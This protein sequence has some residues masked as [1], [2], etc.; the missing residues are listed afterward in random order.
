MAINPPSTTLATIQQKVRRLTRSPST[1]QLSDDDLNQYINTFVV[2]DFPE[3]LRMFN[4]RTV[5][6]FWA[7]P[8]QDVYPTDILSFGSA[9]QAASQPLYDFQNKYLSI[10]DPV[11][12]AGYQSFYTQSREQMFG[13]YPQ[14]N[15]IQAIGPTGDGVTTRFTGFIP[16]ISTSINPNSAQGGAC[17]VKNNVLF[18]SVDVNFNGISMIDQPV[19]DSVTGNP[20]VWGNLYV[21]NQLPAVPVMTG[22]A[23]PYAPN[24]DGHINENNYVNYVTG[25]FVVTFPNAPMQ[26]VLINSQTIPQVVSLPQALM[27]YDDKFTLRPV[28]DQPYQINFEAYVRPTYLLTTSQSPALNEWWQYI[29]Y[30]A[31]KKIFEDR[32]D[33]DSVQLILPEFRKQETLCLRRTIVQYTNERV[34]TIYTEQTSFG[35]GSGAWGWGGGPF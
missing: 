2:Y 30:G 34:A 29:A 32:M 11:Y 21:P 27:F 22:G 28:P 6:K 9:T 1:A 19:I 10:A 7:N 31:A 33:M 25:Q 16:I 26:G 8:Y 17:L 18:D 20:T 12:I 15:N 24:S 3:H 5:F 13:I 14:T 35:P 4:L 23:T